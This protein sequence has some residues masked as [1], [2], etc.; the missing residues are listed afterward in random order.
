MKPKNVFAILAVLA[1]ASP[2]G[3]QMGMG[4]RPPDLSG[5]WHPVVG[6]GAVYETTDGQGKKS[7]L[8]LTIIGKEDVNGKA[9]YWGE[10]V[11]AS[12][13]MGG[14]VVVK[15][16]YTLDGN[17]FAVSRMIMQPPGMDPREMETNSSMGGPRMSSATPSDIRDKSELVGSETI[18]VPAGTFTCEHYRMK[19]GSGDAWISDKVIPLGVVKVQNKDRSMVL[20]KVITDAKDH[21]TGTVKKFDPK[22]NDGHG[23]AQALRLAMSSA[24]FAD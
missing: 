11:M 6:S 5:I 19:D 15:S 22:D 7:Q 8:E 3:A 23:Q 2:I 9:A 18:T 16:L 10:V 12:P 1:L 20:T 13:Q 17:H 24:R 21:I 14:D 4:N